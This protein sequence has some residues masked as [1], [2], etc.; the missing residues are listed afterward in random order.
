MAKSPGSTSLPALTSDMQYFAYKLGCT[1][2]TNIEREAGKAEP[3]LQKLLG[4]AS[5]FDRARYF[6]TIPADS[7]FEEAD[8]AEDLD[9]LES[10][11]EFN[12]EANAL[13]ALHVSGVRDAPSTRRTLS[14]SKACTPYENDKYKPSTVEEAQEFIVDSDQSDRW[15]NTSD[16]SSEDGDDRYYYEDNWSNTISEDSDDDETHLDHKSVDILPKSILRYSTQIY[17][18][19]DSGL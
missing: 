10:L 3:R 5:L 12:E 13:P 8:E 1:S 2:R 14:A 19:H 17:E 6:I 11:Y 16:S 7:G 15:E 18:T 4:H 9:E